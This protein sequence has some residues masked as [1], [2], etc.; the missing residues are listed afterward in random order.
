[1]RARRSGVK[2]QRW[3]FGGVLFAGLVLT[4]HASAA[5]HSAVDVRESLS[6]AETAF[7]QVDYVA[8]YQSC[9]L[10]IEQGHAN[11]KQI[12]RL[13]VLC[14]IS[15]AALDRSDESR[16]HFKVALA[17]RSELRLERELSPKLRSPYLEAQGYWSHFEERLSMK[18]SGGDTNRRLSLKVVDPAQLA[19]KVRISLRA[20]GG[21][22]FQSHDLDPVSS[23]TLQLTREQLAHGV[24]YFAAILDAHDNVL[25]E[26]GNELE[27]IEI[28]PRPLSRAKKSDRLSKAAETP[29]VETSN[30][31]SYWLPIALTG[32][33]L[34]SVGVGVYFSV[35]RENAARRWNSL[36]CEQPGLTRI[37]QCGAVNSDRVH[38]ERASIGFYAAGGALLVTG[39][40][41]LAVRNSAKPGSSPSSAASNSFSCAAA[42][43]FMAVACGGRF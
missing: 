3:T 17:L 26:L 6:A 40:T 39:V 20:I 11:P 25:L 31:G 9:S 28:Q 32:A 38:A 22:E 5:S 30:N 24:S 10:A 18:M 16:A 37:E 13:H 36:S 41:V 34:A 4:A 33:S 15:A 27:P 43:P 1:M 29:V 8:T 35:L 2:L 23:M 14:G 42:L 19:S 12:L 21:S 7:E